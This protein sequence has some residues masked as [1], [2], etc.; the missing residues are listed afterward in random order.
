MARVSS[1]TSCEALN[2]PASPRT[3]GAM[4]VGAHGRQAPRPANRRRTECRAQQ[5]AAHHLGSAVPHLFHRHDVAGERPRTVEDA[6]DDAGLRWSNGRRCSR[7]SGP[8]ADQERMRATQ[9]PAPQMIRC[10]ASGRSGRWDRWFRYVTGQMCA[11][12]LH[13]AEDRVR[14]VETHE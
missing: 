4:A 7:G 2:A 3:A 9:R 14:D 13:E 6:A 12:V 5:D 1:R 11:A 8:G 10:S